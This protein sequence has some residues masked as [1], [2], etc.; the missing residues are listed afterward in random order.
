MI[1]EDIEFTNILNKFFET[2]VNS[3]D[4]TDNKQLTQT[5]N[6]EVPIEI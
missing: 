5:G 4:I 2:A 3:I 6:L 1:T